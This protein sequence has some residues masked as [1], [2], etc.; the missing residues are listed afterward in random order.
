MVLLIVINL[1]RFFL[2]LLG[3]VV[4]LSIVHPMKK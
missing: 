2:K 4:T 1:N 3:R